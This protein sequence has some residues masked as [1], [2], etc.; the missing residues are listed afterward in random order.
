MQSMIE[1]EF[2]IYS[3]R[4]YSSHVLVCMEASLHHFRTLAASHLPG[5]IGIRG[6]LAD[7]HRVFEFAKDFLIPKS[8]F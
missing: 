8:Y 4:F 2:P 1:M 3:H 6:E 7:L 5:F